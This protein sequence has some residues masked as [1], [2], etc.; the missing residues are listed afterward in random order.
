MPQAVQHASLVQRLGSK[1]SPRTVARGGARRFRDAVRDIA[2]DTEFLRLY[3]RCKPHTMTPIERMYA[4]YKAVEYVVSRDIPGEIVECGVWRGGSSMLA[5]LALQ[6]FGDNS[7]KIYL[8]DT[9]EGMTTPSESDRRYDGVAA[10]EILEEVRACA[11][12]EEVEANIG[13]TGMPKERF[14]FVPGAVERTIPTA[15]LNAI[16]L[17]RLDTDWFE[18]TKHEL[19]HLYPQLSEGGVLILDDYGH[20]E[21]A[22]KAVDEYF[23]KLSNAPLLAR[24]DYTGRMAVKPCQS[25]DHRLKV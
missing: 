5:A 23:S 14:V 21:G 10:A 8:F 2:A 25:G 18:S 11:F 17:L 4:L 15:D 3:E 13:S 19:D 16:S 1:L 12:L 7:R 24:I 6:K 22:R 20:W 9:F